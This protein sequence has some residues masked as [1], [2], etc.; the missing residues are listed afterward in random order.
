MSLPSCKPL[1]TPLVTF[2][3]SKLAKMAKGMIFSLIFY[4]LLALFTL[5]AI[6]FARN[7]PEV[8]PGPGMPSLASL[9]LTTADLYNMG[10]PDVEMHPEHADPGVTGCYSMPTPYDVDTSVCYRYL[11][12]IGTHMCSSTGP[13]GYQINFCTSGTAVIT[14]YNDGPDGYFGSV[15]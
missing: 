15:W 2:H 8:I 7:H 14:G 10:P 12:Q 4:G 13:H 5:S 3:L 1:L 6:V 9:N 11:E